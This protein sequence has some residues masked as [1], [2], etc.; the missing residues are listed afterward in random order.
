MFGTPLA[1]ALFG[2]EVLAIGRMRYDALLACA[3][4]SI[5]GDR[6]TAQWGVH[7]TLYQVGTVP[8]LSVRGLTA[9]LVAGGVFGVAGMVFADTTH[10]LSRLVKRYVRRAP[11]RPLLGGELVAAALWH[12][13]AWRFAGL[14]IPTIAASFSNALS[15]SDFAVRTM[16]TVTS[17]GL[18]F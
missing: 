3:V 6:S 9:A 10:L 16:F 17:L 15:L 18:G 12:F 8:A 5:V 7:H 11:L 2:L 14:G 4:G 13:D 1:G